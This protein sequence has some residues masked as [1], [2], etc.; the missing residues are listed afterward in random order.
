MSPFC[1]EPVTEKAVEAKY[2]LRSEAGICFVV[3]PSITIRASASSIVIEEVEYVLHVTD[4]DVLNVYDPT[5]GHTVY[6][7]E[8]ISSPIDRKRTKEN[9]LKAIIQDSNTVSK[10]NSFQDQ[11]VESYWNDESFQA[12]DFQI[13]VLKNRIEIYGVNKS[14]SLYFQ[15]IDTQS[16][17][18]AEEVSS[19]P[20]IYKFFKNYVLTQK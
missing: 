4:Q 14:S 15:V 8:N 6:E 18:S 13:S 17:D 12:G 16:C 20:E 1:K 10:W 2:V 11:I 5:T 19:L 3:L 9:W 7:V